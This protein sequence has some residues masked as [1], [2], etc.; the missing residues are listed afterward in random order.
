VPAGQAEPEVNPGGV[1]WLMF[2]AARGAR[3]RVGGGLLKV[4]ALL[5]GLRD[6]ASADQPTE[7]A[8]GTV[9]P[10]VGGPCHGQDC[11]LSRQ[12]DVHE[13]SATSASAPQ[14]DLLGP[15]SGNCLP[16]GGAV[17][18]LLRQH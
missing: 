5:W 4:A 3:F 12:C 16:A 13:T 11:G 7:Q 1:L 15:M 17:S 18:R 10:D 6:L 9:R 8:E 14:S 2:L